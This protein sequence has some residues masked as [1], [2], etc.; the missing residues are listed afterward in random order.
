MVVSMPARKPLTPRQERALK[1]IGLMPLTPASKI[2]QRFGIPVTKI[3][4]RVARENWGSNRL[5][6]ALVRRFSSSPELRGLLNH[7]KLWGYP[8]IEERAGTHSIDAIR[9]ELS[10]LAGGRK[11]P[12]HYAI[13]SYIK[14]NGLR[15][16]EQA[17]QIAAKPHRTRVENKLSPAQRN[18][19]AEWAYEF[20]EKRKIRTG[21]NYSP[22]EMRGWM[23]DYALADTRFVKM[24]PDFSPE[25]MKSKWFA[26]LVKAARY[27]QLNA[28]R[29]IAKRRPR[30]I[31]TPE[32]IDKRA[33]TRPSVSRLSELEFSKPLSPR[34]KQYLELLLQEKS[35]VEIARELGITQRAVHLLKTAVRKKVRRRKP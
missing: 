27:Y 14:Q 24:S 9:R 32:A 10:T 28:Y 30:E 34:Q 25:L 17:K 26:Y 4:E 35:G 33:R 3:H 5:R 2:A 18:K 12:S 19:L 31:T 6:H 20:F 15:T 13:E 21:E 22:E 8:L 1:K 16:A 29:R 7:P 23:I 11:I